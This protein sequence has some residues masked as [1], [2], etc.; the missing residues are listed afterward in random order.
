MSAGEELLV[1]GFDLVGSCQRVL[2]GF[3]THGGQLGSFRGG[4]RAQPLAF[5][6]SHSTRVCRLLAD[7]LSLDLSHSRH[8][9]PAAAHDRLLS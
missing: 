9:T 6:C 5:G 2:A 4:D 3:L 1:H 8:K 7:L